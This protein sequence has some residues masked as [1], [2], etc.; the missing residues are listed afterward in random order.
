MGQ[1]HVMPCR[2]VIY[3]AEGRDGVGNAM[4]T[5]EPYV[6]G[7]NWDERGREGTGKRRPGDRREMG[8]GSGEEGKGAVLCCAVLC[9][10]VQYVECTTV[11]SSKVCIGGRRPGMRGTMCS[12]LAA[13]HIAVQ[14]SK[15]KCCA[16]N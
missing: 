3:D 14:E 10:A 7:E 13:Q 6:V 16:E 15:L 11:Q 4:C 8:E 1:C 2:V 5:C 12:V 9:C